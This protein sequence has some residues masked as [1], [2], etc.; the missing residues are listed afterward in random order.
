MPQKPMP[1]RSTIQHATFSIINTD[2]M[3]DWIPVLEKL[4]WP[5][6]IVILLVVFRDKLN[7]LY[8]MTTQ[9]RS[10][11]IAGWIKIGEQVQ[12]T[13]I[14]SFASHDLSLEAVERDDHVVDKGGEGQLRQLQDKL[15]NAE[16]QSIDILKV[17]DNKIYDKDLLLKYISTLGI[18]YVVF[19]KSGVFDGW[20]NS[21]VFSGQLLVGEER[22]FNYNRLRNSL[23]GIREESVAPDMKTS[24]VLTKM[25]DS[26]AD[27]LAV[28]DEGTFKYIVNKQDILTALVSNTILS[29]NP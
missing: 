18:K 19:V 10:L 13:D 28:V 5:V 2:I 8:Q 24:D 21:S 25:K 15:R 29:D 9:G 11:E 3:K 27:D 17:T 1:P 12:N 23:A 22:T 20:I 16:L 14:N 4:I 7:G 6:F 26:N